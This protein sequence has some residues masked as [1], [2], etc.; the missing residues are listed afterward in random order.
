MQLLSVQMGIL[1][2]VVHSII[3]FI[4]GLSKYVMTNS[5]HMD[6]HLS[7][8]RDANVSYSHVKD[9]SLVKSYKGNGGI[10]E[11]CWNTKGDKVAACFSNNTV[12][13]IDFRI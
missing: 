6:R 13:V 5:P 4:F 11:V 8:R 7:F 2:R 10:F 3:T 9:G 12:V 1:L